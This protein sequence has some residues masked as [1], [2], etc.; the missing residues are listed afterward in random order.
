MANAHFDP[1]YQSGFR[2]AGYRTGQVGPSGVVWEN[3]LAA[4]FFKVELKTA[5]KQWGT[6]KRHLDRCRSSGAS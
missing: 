4:M 3:S 6:R 5:V 2:I 1:F